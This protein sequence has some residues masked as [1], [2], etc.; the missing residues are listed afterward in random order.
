MSP[1]ALSGPDDGPQVV[2]VGDLVAHHQQG[3]LALVPGGLKDAL[4]TDVLPDRRQGDD[5]L[6]GMGAAHG[7]QLPPVRLHHHHA[8]RPGFGG[9]MS[10]GLVRLSL[11]EVNFVNRLP[12]PQGL[13]DGVAPLDD[14]VGLGSQV[15][16]SPFFHNF[17][18]NLSIFAFKR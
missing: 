12:C 10:Q 9:N 13:N 17:S 7:V 8:R 18:L 1:G 4:H 2:G 14:A 3:G 5:A 6:V 16:L 11:L 15:L